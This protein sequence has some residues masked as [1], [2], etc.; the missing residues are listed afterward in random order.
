MSKKLSEAQL[1]LC[2]HLKELGLDSETEFQIEPF[3]RWRADIAVPS[4][5]MLIEC[6]GGIYSGGHKR[7]AA[8]EDDYFKQ[9]TAQMLGWKLLRFSN[10]QVLIGEAKAFIERYL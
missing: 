7:G 3:H 2:V 9:N 6:D 4:L 10:R 1:L 5:R 8:L